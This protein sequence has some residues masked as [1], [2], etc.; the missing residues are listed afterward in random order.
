M[1]QN[2]VGA[3]SMRRKVVV[4]RVA[5]LVGVLGLGGALVPACGSYEPGDGGGEGAAG[6][7]GGAGGMGGLGGVAGEGGA[8]GGTDGTGGASAEEPE[9]CDPT[10]DD[11]DG[12]GVLY[13][14]PLGFDGAAGTVTDPIQTMKEALQR[15]AL[16]VNLGQAP[17]VIHACATA[18]R[19]TE[20]LQINAEH[21]RIGIFGG[22]ECELFESSEERA[23][24]VATEPSGHRIE[25]ADWVI[26]KNLRLK[27][28]DASVPAESSRV[29]TVIDST[30]VR[31]VRSELVAGAGAPGVDGEGVGWAE[32]AEAGAPG[33]PG[34]EACPNNQ[35]GINPGGMSVTTRCSDSSRSIGGDGGPGADGTEGFESGYPGQPGHPS[36]GT[37][38]KGE[39]TQSCTDGGHGEPGKPGAPG[40]P[41]EPFGRLSDA[42]YL[43]PLGGDGAAGTIGGGGGGGGGSAKPATCAMGASGGSGGGGGCPGVGATGGQG[44]GGSFGLVTVMSALELSQVT[45][46]L[47]QGGA[48]GRGGNGQVGGN[49]AEGGLPGDGAGVG[50]DACAG[51]HGGNGGGGGA[52]AGGAGGPAIGV[53][54][55]GIAPTGAA[56]V[57]LPLAAQGGY[58]G[59]GHLGG[60]GVPGVVEE[61]R[62]F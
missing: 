60:S 30:G 38:G 27:S 56:V 13:V 15:A 2:W 51:G 39:E 55:S 54:Y 59:F 3:G 16:R 47:A 11:C 23:T 36:G 21:G 61:I 41:S 26:L 45:I 42:G 58:P 12:P 7:A 14:S 35:F 6:G 40:L 29:L 43:P 32:R 17:P 20:T 19:Y 46:T 48:G 25:G 9:F 22:F 57:V 33:N 44:G 34:N 5:A 31:I 1:K 4:A 10:V 28:P 52:G 8:A 53:A 49:G 50:N 18:G 37:A 62:S 24:F